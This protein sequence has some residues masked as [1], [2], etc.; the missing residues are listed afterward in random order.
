MALHCKSF[1]KMEV[2]KERDPP[3]GMA[4]E[5]L[6]LRKIGQFSA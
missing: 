1:S 6:R 5:D 4:T 3:K 2:Y